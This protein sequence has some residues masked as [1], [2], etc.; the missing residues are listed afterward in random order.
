MIMVIENIKLSQK[1]KDQLIKLKRY[2]KIQNWNVLC[3]WAFC[4]SLAD[5]EKPKNLKIPGDSSVEMTW[6]VFGG[7]YQKL[8]TALLKLR[9]QQDGL[10]TSN[11]V[12][13][14]QFRLHLHRGIDYL[15][16]NKDIKNISTFVSKALV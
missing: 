4:I 11:K 12:L 5:P 2:T 13:A 10:D 16:A 9:C 15:A 14:N 8:Y 1:A 3:R 7:K 6:K